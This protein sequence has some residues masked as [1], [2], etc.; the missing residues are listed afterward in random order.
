MWSEAEMREVESER[1]PEAMPTSMP[2]GYG[3]RAGRLRQT[4]SQLNLMRATASTPHELSRGHSPSVIYAPSNESHGNFIDASY[5]RICAK[6]AWRKRLEKAHTAKRQAR[7]SGPDEE[8]RGWCELDSASSSDALLMNIF[9]YPRVL[10]RPDLPALLGV[11]R[12]LI[13]EFGYR[14]TATKIRKLTDRT[15]IDMRLGNLFVEAK[16][17]ETGFQGAPLRLI[18]RYTA[19]D[20]VFDR[21]SLDT[22]SAGIASYQLL[23]GVLAA[24]AEDASFC[25]FCDARRPDLIAAWY[26][27]MC[28]VRSYEL[29]ARLRLVTWQEIASTVPLPLRKFL[30]TKYGIAAG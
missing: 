28:A 8:R 25:V 30:A 3:A 20:E 23:R 21:D 15:E 12:G 13:P 17:T 9:C 26:A 1:E 14:A 19:F 29:R 27:V 2:R 11:D 5:R 4:I 24:H 22:T 7:S 10:A 6:P 16:L 18:E